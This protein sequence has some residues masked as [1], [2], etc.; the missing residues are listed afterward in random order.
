MS[1]SASG[2]EQHSNSNTSGRIG[3]IFDDPELVTSIMRMPSLP[4][5]SVALLDALPGEQ[6]VGQLQDAPARASG[7]QKPGSGDQSYM[8][9]EESVGKLR[10]LCSFT[11]TACLNA[12]TREVC[13]VSGALRKRQALQEKSKKAQRRYRERKKAPLLLMHI[14]HVPAYSSSAADGLNARRLSVTDS[15]PWQMPSVAVAG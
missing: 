8:L 1:S 14:N 7:L 15:T 5:H 3:N 13:D 6:F 2:A 9:E 10:L 4:G 12:P 11:W